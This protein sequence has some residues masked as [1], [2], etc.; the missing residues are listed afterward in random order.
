MLTEIERLNVAQSEPQKLIDLLSARAAIA[1]AAGDLAAARAAWKPMGDLVSTARSW[2]LASA[3]RAALWAGDAAGAQADLA[4]FDASGLHGL[5]AE[6]HR[7]NIRAGLAALEG[8]PVE[9]LGLYRQ[10]SQ[11]WRDIGFLWLEALTAIDM[12]TLLDPAEPEVHAAAEAARE[13]LT[14]LGAKPFLERLDAAMDAKEALA[15]RN[16]ARG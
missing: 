14:R 1:F 4:E 15:P 13:T 16:G 8:L 10:A 5:T 3:A 9:A 11:G 6:L 2:S 12:A 7:A